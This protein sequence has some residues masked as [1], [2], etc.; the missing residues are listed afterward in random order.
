MNYY[1]LIYKASGTPGKSAVIPASSEDAARQQL[2]N[3]MDNAMI[4]SV[5]PTDRSNYVNH[6]TGSRLAMWEAVAAADAID[7]CEDIKKLKREENKMDE[8]EKLARP[9]KI[10]TEMLGPEA[11]PEQAERMAE[12][13]VGMGYN[14]AYT[15]DMGAVNP[16]SC[17][18]VTDAAWEQALGKLQGAD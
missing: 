2:H 17:D 9:Y 13:L 5:K 7:K 1:R 15:A 10:N 3:A 11:T 6:I 8:N 16:D 4:T 18:S 12:I 14:A